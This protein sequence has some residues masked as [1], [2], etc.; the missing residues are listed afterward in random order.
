MT[1]A[2]L[3]YRPTTRDELLGLLDDLGDDAKLLAGGTAFTILRK[4]GLLRPE[5]VISLLS[6]PDLGGI[7]RVDGGTRIGALTRLRSIEDS[8]TV[9]EHHPV[10]AAAVGLVANRRVRNV[11]TMGGNVSEADPTSDPPGVLRALDAVMHLTSRRG[12]RQVG[13]GEFFVDYF[14]TALRE[15]EIVSHVVVPD[16]GPSWSGTYLKFLSRSAEDRTC[17]GVAAFVDLDGDTCRGLRLALVGMGPVPLRVPDAEQLAVGR[18][19]DPGV[20]AEVAAAYVEA[21]DPVSD[22]RGSADYRRKAAAALIHDAVARA[23]TGAD[24]AVFA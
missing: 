10:L 17:I 16:L 5:H 2:P 11:A 7:D 22:V 20:V 19:V 14:E 21:S 18:R 12:D 8:G 15:D 1:G 13:A 3:M 4:S 23:A 9:R 24:D 6:V